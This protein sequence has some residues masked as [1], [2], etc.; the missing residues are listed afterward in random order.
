MNL[1]RSGENTA[2]AAGVCVCVCTWLKYKLKMH[3]VP[4]LH[5]VLYVNLKQVRP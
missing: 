3:D 4:D 5:P 2:M 1:N